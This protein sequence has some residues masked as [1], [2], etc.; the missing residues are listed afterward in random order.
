MRG[1]ELR[2]LGFG[3][4]WGVGKAAEEPPALVVLSFEPPASAAAAAAAATATV[5]T[6]AWVGKGIV[7]DTGGLS[8]KV[9][10][11][12]VGMKSDMAGSAAMLAAFEAAVALGTK[13]RVHLVLCLAE[14]AIGPKAMR[15]DDVLKLLSG[16]TVLLISTQKPKSQELFY[17]HR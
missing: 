10:G 6:V 16:K 4:L 15:N 11:G 9:G 12:M 2:D 7:Y 8:L 3:G 14:N 1:E 17:Q 5:E 13:Q